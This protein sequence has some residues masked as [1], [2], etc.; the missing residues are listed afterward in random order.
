MSDVEENMIKKSNS[1]KNEVW[2]I[3]YKQLGLI[4]FT[5]VLGII[6]TLLFSTT[7]SSSTST[8]SPTDLI[9]FVLSVILSS[10]SIVLAIVAISLGKSSEKVIM[11]RNDE[12]IRLQNDVFLKTTDALQRIQSSTGVTEKRIEDIISGR[13]GDMSQTLAEELSSQK[14]NGINK[15][16]LEEEIRESLMKSIQINE[17]VDRNEKRKELMLKKRKEQKKEKELYDKLHFGTLTKILNEEELI[18]IKSP[19]HGTVNSEGLKK[20]DCIVEKD[21]IKLGIS[22]FDSHVDSTSLSFAIFSILGDIDNKIIDRYLI[23]VFSE[24]IPGG[25]M[26]TLSALSDDYKSNI[27][28]KLYEEDKPIS[29]LLKNVL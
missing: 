21:N 1:S 4:I 27:H 5:F 23:I 17:R 22:T 19:T 9:N 18:I 8:F 11:E 28:L 12:S 14:Q 13:V 20:Y 26:Q 16:E 3:S 24:K 25:A 10:A 15:E 2:V 6:S 29:S 7:L